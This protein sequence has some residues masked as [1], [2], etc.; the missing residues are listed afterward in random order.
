MPAPIVLLSIGLVLDLGGSPVP[1]DIPTV[2]LLRW[3]EDAASRSRL[4]AARL[5]R[6][7]LIS[8]DEA[9][10]V[11]VDELEDWIRFPLDPAELAI[12][13]ETL[14]ERAREVAP[15]AIG[16]VLDGD[17]VLHRDDRWVALPP[18]EARLFAVLLERSGRVVD[19]AALTDACWPDGAPADERAVDGVVKR[20]R[21]RIAPLDVRIHTV[22]GNG[23]LLDHVD[24]EV[25]G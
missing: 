7:L 8:A 3:P 5:P 13:T 9:P 12:R 17:G 21:R 19:R 16:L 1:P 4:A 23:F 24:G 14:L 18:T 22:A 20:L 6:L 10:P 25:E 15:R 11:S 2:A